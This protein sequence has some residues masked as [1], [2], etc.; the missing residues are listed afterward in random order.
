MKYR[1]KVIEEIHCEMGRIVVYVDKRDEWR[2]KAVSTNGRIVADSGE[3]YTRRH[4]LNKGLSVAMGILSDKVI[5][6]HK[7][8]MTFSNEP[9]AQ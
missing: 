4:S 7:T 8:L 6:K 2:W 1:T 9:G 5:R 3:G